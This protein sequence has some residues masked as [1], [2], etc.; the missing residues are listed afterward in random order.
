MEDRFQWEILMGYYPLEKYLQQI[1]T[2][3]LNSGKYDLVEP[4]EWIQ[5]V[6]K[7]FIVIEVSG[8]K[9]MNIRT[10]YLTGETDIWWNIIKN[11]L[12][13]FSFKWSRIAEEL[14]ALL[15]IAKWE[16]TNA[17]GAVALGT[18]LLPAPED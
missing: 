6:G 11:R 2:I 16:L 1:H 17:C 5:G 8:D 3:E 7:I 14:T 4:W 18:S 15:R 12:I 13:G 9:R 10:C